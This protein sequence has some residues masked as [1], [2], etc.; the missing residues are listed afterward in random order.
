MP[1]VSWQDEAR[2]HEY[3]PELFFDP[4][5]RSE[6]RAKSVCKRCEVRSECLLMALE[7]RAEFGVWGGLTSKERRKLI[8]QV[9][10]TTDWVPVLQRVGLIV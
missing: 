1:A 3:D 7:S 5:R 6:R 2:C 10:K 4:H 8:R 9:P